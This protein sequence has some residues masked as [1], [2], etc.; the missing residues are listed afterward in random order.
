M[1]LVAVGLASGDVALYKLYGGGA[2]MGRRSSRSSLDG[3]YSEPLRFLSLYDWGYGPDALGPVAAL[4][5]APDNRALAVRTRA[6]RLGV[7]LG[8]ASLSACAILIAQEGS[9]LQSSASIFGKFSEFERA[10]VQT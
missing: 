8:P 1:Q 2:S 3:G 6:L 10:A 4:Q 5:W 7:E 9:C